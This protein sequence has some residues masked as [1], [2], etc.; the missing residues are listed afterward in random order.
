M[1]ECSKTAFKDLSESVFVLD[2][3]LESSL[4]PSGKCSK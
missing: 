3:L 1:C 4:G 2:R